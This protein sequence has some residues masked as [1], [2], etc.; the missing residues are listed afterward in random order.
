M[1]K[2]INL[3]QQQ[4]DRIKQVYLTGEKSILSLAQEL[5]IDRL[6]V[7]RGAREMGLVKAPTIN[8]HSGIKVEWTD[9]M[10]AN[11]I[12]GYKNPFITVEDL[13][14]EMGL[15]SCT[16][17][18]KAKELGMKKIRKT[19]WNAD[20]I[21]KL[22][23]LA[24][25]CTILQLSEHLEICDDVVMR[26]VKEL[27][28]KYY[29]RALQTEEE[30]QEKRRIYRASRNTKYIPRMINR[31]YP[32]IIVKGDS[33]K[34]KLKAEFVFDLSNPR[35]TSYDIAIKYD[36]KSSA[37]NFWRNKLFGKVQ[38][39][40]DT[41]KRITSAERKVI[42]II[43]NLDYAYIPHKRIENKTVDI[44]MG[45]KRFI[46]VDGTY[47]HSK[48]KRKIKDYLIRK[49]YKEKGYSILVIKEA[50]LKNKILVKSRIKAFM[51]NNKDSLVSNDKSKTA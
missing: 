49:S 38:L 29:R 51:S 4:Y 28:L 40:L 17:Q 18:Y 19:A 48:L 2:K 36:I 50:E 21:E 6:V 7:K 9:D 45:K 33:G 43:E 1:G 39:R 30:K 34:K 11:L 31:L 42:E 32:E 26:K 13:A 37:V 44:Y 25:E 8:S 20:K 47:W 22:K 14:A 10:L 3:T 5:G 41:D 27:D 23:E 15:A 16:L 24:S 35:Y 12:N 46:E